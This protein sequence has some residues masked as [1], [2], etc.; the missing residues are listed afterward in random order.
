[1]K[2]PP[3]SNK[4]AM[5]EL[6]DLVDRE[7]HVIGKATRQQVHG[8]PDLIHR[9]IHILI[10]NSVGEWY[11]QRRSWNK[12]TQPG[13]WDTAV[14]GHVDSGET[15]D[16]AAQREMEEELGIVDIKPNFL[17][18]FFH[19]NE[20]ESE[21]VSTYSCTWNGEFLLNSDEILAGRFWH[22]DEIQKR[23]SE[24]LFT[25]QFLEELDRHQDHIRR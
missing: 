5:E 9:V 4:S 13:K 25:P 6:F 21:I 18:K 17:Y 22:L 16:A 8:N 12:D 10:F 19:T 24:G 23:K 7:D 20:F 1:M 15:Y 3:D 11:L 14:G 2:N